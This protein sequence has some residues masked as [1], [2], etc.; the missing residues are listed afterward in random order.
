MKF[1]EVDEG[2]IAAKNYIFFN[3]ALC[4]N[5]PAGRTESHKWPCSSIFGIT[6]WSNCFDDDYENENATNL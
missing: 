2:L 5:Y 6:E 4:K 1:D 3:D